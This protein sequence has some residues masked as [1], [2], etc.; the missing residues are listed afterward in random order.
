MII[1]Q[2]LIILLLLFGLKDKVRDVICDVQI[3]IECDLFVFIV[4]D[5]KGLIR[6][7]LRIPNSHNKEYMDL[8]LRNPAVFSIPVVSCFILLLKTE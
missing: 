4:R 6:L 2:T 7:R 5:V 1:T 8:T 3:T